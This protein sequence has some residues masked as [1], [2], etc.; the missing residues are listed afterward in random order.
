MALA[1][2]A[3][4]VAAFAP[5][6]TVLL[7]ARIVGG[8]SAGLAYPTTLALITALWSGPARTRSIAMWSAL[9]GGAAMLGPLLAG[10]LLEFFAWGR[11]SSSRSPSRS[12]PCTW[13]GRTSPPTST[14]PTGRVD[15]IGGILSAIMIGALV[16]A[17]NFITVPNLQMLA[18]GLLVAA[19]IV[20]LL[21][22][23]RQKRA[24][25][26]LYDLKML[27]RKT[28]WV[29]AIGGIIVF[30]SLMGIA[31]V[32]Q[33]Y[34]QNVLGYGTLAAGAAI[35][36]AVFFMVVVA[37]RSAKLVHDRG[38]R[39]TLLRGRRSWLSPSWACSSCGRKTAR[40][41]SSPSRS[42]SWASASASPA[43]RRPTR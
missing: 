19:V 28:F 35:L 7:G 30:G 11:S 25:N 26:P 1:I 27:A 36:P 23:F 22:V 40:T 41:G 29:A 3:S 43:H 6:D 38:S 17:L 32:N 14:S 37:P 31:F 9:G 42:A 39:A 8:V 34:L 18:I 10:L 21:F 24:A 20:L 4:L 13:P 33:Q 15:N 2:P 12:S 5:S 16:V